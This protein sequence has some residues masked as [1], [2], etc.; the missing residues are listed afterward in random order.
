MV[1][2]PVQ[3]FIMHEDY[4]DDGGWR[5][6]STGFQ[7]AVQG[8]SAPLGKCTM[9]SPDWTNKIVA[10]ILL[11]PHYDKFGKPKAIVVEALDISDR[12]FHAAVIQRLL[13]L[14][15]IIGRGLGVSDQRAFKINKDLKIVAA[16]SS[17][18]SF[19][20][21][22][23]LFGE[24]DQ[25]MVFGSGFMGFLHEAPENLTLMRRC[26]EV[27]L[28]G[29]DRK[30]RVV[31]WMEVKQG[32]LDMTVSP[33]YNQDGDID[34]VIIAVETPAALEVDEIGMVVNC[35][36]EAIALLNMD[37]YRLLGHKFLD[38][39]DRKMKKQ[40]SLAIYEV[41]EDTTHKYQDLQASHVLDDL[42][43]RDNRN[44]PFGC[45]ASITRFDRDG[46]KKLMVMLQKKPMPQ[47]VDDEQSGDKQPHDN[48]RDTKLK[49]GDPEWQRYLGTGFQV[50]TTDL[51]H[52]EVEQDPDYQQPWFDAWSQ[53]RSAI[54][55]KSRD[56]PEYH[57]TYQDFQ[58]YLIATPK[59]D[60]PVGMQRLNLW[61][62]RTVIT[63]FKEL[64]GKS[65]GRITDPI[66]KEQFIQWWNTDRM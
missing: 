22:Q 58:A 19:F 8:A 24:F 50:E 27:A 20:E 4:C 10:N 16:T 1:G 43:L 37:K 12:L 32:K 30:C 48:W 61:K 14:N 46:E 65:T 21:W 38:V 28:Q 45:E 2:R 54:E 52:V 40:A 15:H 42:R 9:K 56:I 23:D 6:F 17:A 29:E 18:L 51:D 57:C 13:P 62:K 53:M 7:S 49:E 59:E 44:A 11:S 36:D 60:R 26:I 41:L 64:H 34:G 66:T 3:E 33:S 55:D 5:L 31:P 25:N 47:R 39:V 35:N 63:K